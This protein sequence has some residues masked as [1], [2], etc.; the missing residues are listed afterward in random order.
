MYDISRKQLDRITQILQN[1]VNTDES[2]QLGKILTDADIIPKLYAYTYFKKVKEEMEQY[3]V[4]SKDF[5]FEDFT[6]LF[7]NVGALSLGE[8]RN[9]SEARIVFTILKN[10]FAREGKFCDFNDSIFHSSTRRGMCQSEEHDEDKPQKEQLL[11][12][13]YQADED[14]RKIDESCEWW[15]RNCSDNSDGWEG[16]FDISCD[17]ELDE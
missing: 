13:I 17:M 9:K 8:I 3:N 6:M 2:I 10:G 15:C 7:E 11:F 12:P 16:D 4:H 14:T 1:H 5:D